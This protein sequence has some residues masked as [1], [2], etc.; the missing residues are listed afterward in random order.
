MGFQIA[1]S[2]EALVAACAWERFQP[3]VCQEVSFEITAPAERLAAVYTLV[4]FHS[5]TE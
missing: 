1:E 4:R 5:W 3:S 2:S